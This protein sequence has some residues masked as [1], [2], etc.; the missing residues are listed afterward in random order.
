MRYNKCSQLLTNKKKYW[1]K[2]VKQEG[3]AKEVALKG[4]VME[5][6]RTSFTVH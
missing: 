2:D 6:L 4:S 1:A 3:V 5:Q